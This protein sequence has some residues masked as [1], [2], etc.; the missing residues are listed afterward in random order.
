MHDYNKYIVVPLLVK[1]N[2]ELFRYS[3]L[4]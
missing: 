3:L 2:F 1:A 4:Y